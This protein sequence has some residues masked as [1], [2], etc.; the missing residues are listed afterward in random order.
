MKEV[1]IVNKTLGQTPLQAIVEFKAKNPEYQN[2]PITYA[3]RLDPMA[4]G[5]LILLCGT[6]IQNK[7]EYMNLDKVYQA[8]IILGVQ[9]DSYDILGLVQTST[10]PKK[11]INFVNNLTKEVIEKALQ[12]FSGNISLPLPAYSSP[13]VKGKALFDWAKDGQI[14]DIEIP[15]KQSTVYEISLDKMEGLSSAEVLKYILNTVPLVKGDFR[16]QQTLNRWQEAQLPE[17]LT[18]IDITVHCSSGTYIRS[19]T[20]ELG[21]KLGCG[22]TLLSLKRIKVGDF[23]LPN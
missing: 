8:K 23:K 13:T 1:I 17:T 15:E 10:D 3:G 19:I 22:A 2:T 6:A 7:K 18:C 4:E 20:N 12:K 9:T 21:N 14:E 11:I 16:Q 5:L